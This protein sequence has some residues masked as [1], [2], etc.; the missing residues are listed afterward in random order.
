[1]KFSCCRFSHC[2]T[3]NLIRYVFFIQDVAC[4]FVTFYYIKKNSIRRKVRFESLFLTENPG[5]FTP[6]RFFRF[7]P[8]LGKTI[9]CILPFPLPPPGGG[10]QTIGDLERKEVCLRIPRFILRT[11]RFPLVTPGYKT[12]F[13]TNIGNL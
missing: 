11:A 4:Q 1:M 3:S 13:G 12:L 6:K 7:L 9:S 2:A 10:G 5:D 8:P